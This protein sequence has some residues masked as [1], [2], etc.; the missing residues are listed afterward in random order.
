MSYSP[1]DLLNPAVSTARYWV[2]IPHY[3]LD[4]TTA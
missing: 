3:N 2:A 4:G 1:D